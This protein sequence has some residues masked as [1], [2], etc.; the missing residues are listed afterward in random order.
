MPHVTKRKNDSGAGN[1]LHNWAVFCVLLT[2]PGMEGATEMRT[3]LYSLND[4][5]SACL[6]IFQ[7]RVT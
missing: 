4:R 1:C 7:E 2:E 5:R 6:W 3:F